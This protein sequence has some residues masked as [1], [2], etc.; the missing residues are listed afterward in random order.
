[1]PYDW[2][3]CPKEIHTF[4]YHLINGIMDITDDCIGFYLHGSLAMGGFNPTRSDIDILVVTN[5]SMSVHTKRKLATL[6]LMQSNSPYPVEISFLNENQLVKWVHPCPFEFHYSEFWRER[7]EQELLHNTKKDLNNAIQTDGDLAAHIMIMNE[8]GVCLMGKPINEV[9]PV[10]PQSDYLSSILS[11]YKD[12]VKNMEEDPV[13]SILNMIRVYRYL[14]EGKISSK[15]EAGI[16]ALSSFPKELSETIKKVMACYSDEKDIYSF[17][18][19]EL[20][21]IENY[22]SE[23]ICRWFG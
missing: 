5:K 18:R 4:V 15:Q 10:V 21:Q 7:Y 16:W 20:K 11:D 14:K 22:L 19:N 8:R 23:K 9:F 17:T 1:M 12:C 2:K 13:Y 3:T 6:F